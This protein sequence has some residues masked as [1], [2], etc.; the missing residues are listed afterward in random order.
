MF[1]V[2][3]GN[4]LSYGLGN[5]LGYMFLSLFTQHKDTKGQIFTAVLP[6][7]ML[8]SGVC[9]YIYMQSWKQCTLS[10]ITT[11]ALWQLTHLHLASVRFEHYIYIYI[12]IYTYIYILK[13]IYYTIYI[14]T[15][16]HYIYIYYILHYIYILKVLV[17]LISFPIIIYD[18]G[19]HLPWNLQFILQLLFHQE[20]IKQHF[21]QEL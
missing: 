1:S 15:I 14:Y 2:T 19:A 8:N 20:A 18:N 3:V 17:L 7:D 12:Y 6:R 10:V 21:K 4:I 5:L 13:Y 16:L 9:L 11:M